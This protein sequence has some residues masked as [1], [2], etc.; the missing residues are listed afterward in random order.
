MVVGFLKG[1]WGKPAQPATGMVGI[2]G[3][4]SS[5]PSK[6]VSTITSP[7]KLIMSIAVIGG[8]LLLYRRYKK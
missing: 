2:W 3:T 6:L 8:G 1:I 5:V 7:S 4:I